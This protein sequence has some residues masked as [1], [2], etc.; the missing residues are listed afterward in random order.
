MLANVKQLLLIRYSWYLMDSAMNHQLLVDDS[1]LF[2]RQMMRLPSMYM[3]SV[4][5][6]WQALVR[7]LTK[8]VHRFSLARG[9]GGTLETIIV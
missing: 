6:Y 5:V 8:I 7:V 4:D 9:C 3:R 1:L 2:L